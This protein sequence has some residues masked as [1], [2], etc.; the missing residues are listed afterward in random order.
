MT[1]LSLAIVRDRIARDL[2]R[3]EAERLADETFAA[4]VRCSVGS[5][6]RYKSRRRVANRWAREC[7]APSPADCPGARDVLHT[8]A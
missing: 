7:L 5:G 4:G 1:Y 2:E 6:C 8:S 3:T